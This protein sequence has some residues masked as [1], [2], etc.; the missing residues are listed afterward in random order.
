M[1]ARINMYIICTYIVF[2]RVRLSLDT[3]N[4][5]LIHD[6]MSVFVVSNWKNKEKHTIVWRKVARFI[7]LNVYGSVYLYYAMLYIVFVVWSM[8]D[9]YA[10]LLWCKPHYCYIFLWCVTFVHTPHK[11]YKC[12][13][14]IIYIPHIHIITKISQ[15]CHTHRTTY[16]Y[17]P[18]IHA[19]IPT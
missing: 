19:H 2:M 9:R 11:C 1:C 13:K 18:N 14:N 10:V 5:F 8:Y 3:T 6:Q 7:E 12:H 15:T 17:I 4:D 16:V